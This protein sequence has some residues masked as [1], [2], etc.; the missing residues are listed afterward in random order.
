MKNCH[1]PWMEK[2]FLPIW[3]QCLK[4]TFFIMMLILSVVGLMGTGIYGLCNLITGNFLI[5]F[6]CSLYNNVF[7][8]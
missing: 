8:I 1:Y 3:K 5:G 6:L 4:K 7:A 2:E